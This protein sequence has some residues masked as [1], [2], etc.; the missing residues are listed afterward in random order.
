MVYKLPKHRGTNMTIIGA[1]TNKSNKIYYN[2]TYK[3]CTLTVMDFFRYLKRQFNFRNKVFVMD[4]HKS[5]HSKIILN[6][7]E[8]YGGIVLFMPAISSYFN[9]IETIW[10]WVK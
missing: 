3:T 1:I 5:H 6:F 7:I 4:N 8:K 9:P 10:S 2:V